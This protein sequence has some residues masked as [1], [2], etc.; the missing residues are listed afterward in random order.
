MG[1]PTLLLP[2]VLDPFGVLGWWEQLF[3]LGCSFRGLEEDGIIVASP[4][5]LFENL[6]WLPFGGLLGVASASVG[7]VLTVYYSCGSCISG[8]P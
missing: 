8:H 3:F 5:P 1:L 7:A 6:M 2:G 4:P